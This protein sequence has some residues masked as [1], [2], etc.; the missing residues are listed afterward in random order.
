MI[1]AHCGDMVEA[2]EPFALYRGGRRRGRRPGRWP[3]PTG[4]ATSSGR[5]RGRTGAVSGTS[6]GAA[7]AAGIPAITAEVGGCGIVEQ[8]AVDAHVR[9]L[10]AVL[11]QLGMA[12]P[13][14]GG[15]SSEPVY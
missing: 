13:G 12:D 3:W 4:S 14:R 7:A 8:C 5:S 1:D 11:A 6:S 10:N 2:L 15:C 9:G